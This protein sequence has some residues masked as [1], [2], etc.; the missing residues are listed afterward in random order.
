LWSPNPTGKVKASIFCQFLLK[1]LDLPEPMK[2]K[3]EM[4]DEQHFEMI[5]IL[6][7]PQDLAL[8]QEKLEFF[9][10]IL[11]KISFRILF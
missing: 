9:G 8:D 11:F 5:Q 7:L 6:I 1:R 3:L 2:G 4:T 10:A